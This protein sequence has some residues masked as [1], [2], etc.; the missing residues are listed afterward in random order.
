MKT[1]EYNGKTYYVNGASGELKDLLDRAHKGSKEHAIFNLCKPVYFYNHK[2]FQ[3]NPDY[4]SDAVG[5]LENVKQPTAGQV[6]SCN[7]L[8]F[9]I[10]WRRFGLCN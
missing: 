3:G 1:V 9:G 4:L 8:G 10:P 2:N 7:D 6:S 5:I